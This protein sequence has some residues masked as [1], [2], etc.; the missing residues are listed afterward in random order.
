MVTICALKHGCYFEKQPLLRKIISDEIIEIQQYFPNITILERVVMPNHIHL[1]ISINYQVE[2]VNLG[3]VI[4]V[5]K[6]K[7]INK[8]LKVIK[9]NKINEIGCI[10]QRNYFERRIRN[11]EEYKN[12]KIY[13]E[14]NP[15]KWKQ[16]VENPD[17]FKGRGFASRNPN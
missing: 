9:E 14:L 10:W 8:W 15:L 7:T 5:F 2:A 11:E 4:N 17:N 13:I 1:I 16:D 3:K 6:G 12:C